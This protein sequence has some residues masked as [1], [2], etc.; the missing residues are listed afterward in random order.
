MDVQI[1]SGDEHRRPSPA[2]WWSSRSRGG[3]RRRA[4]RSAA[5]SRCS[6]TSTSPASTTRSSS[7]STAFPTRT[8]T[9][10]VAEATRLG[11]AVARDGHPRPDR[12]PPLA[13]GDDRRRARA[14][15]RRRDHARAAAERQLLARRPHRGRRALRAARAGALDE[16]A[17]ERGTSVYFPERAVHM[18]PAE[19]STGLCSLNPHVDRL[20]QSCLMEVDRRGDGRPLRAARR[21][22][23]QRRA[24]DVHR[25]ERHP[26]RSRSGRRSTR[27][28]D[29]RAAVRDDAR[30]VRDPEQAPPPPRLDRLRPEGAGDRPRRRGAWSRRSSRAE[31]NVAH[32]LIEEF[33]L[34]ANE[35]VAQ[36]LDEQRRADAVPHPRGAGPAEGRASSRSSSR[37]SATASARRPTQVKPRH[38]QKLVEKMRGTPEEKPIAFLMLRTMQKARYDAAEPRAL[39]PRGGELHALHVADPPLS[40]PRRPPHAARVA[41]RRR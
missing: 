11:T 2:T 22:D 21:R 4:A 9:E 16:E 26:D 27:Y 19:L 25:G 31:R 18:F 28:R 6:A 40:R 7:A 5:S 29:A 30:A 38:F 1:P 36:H 32:R 8:A 12:F 15:L 37:R 33:M 17:Y 39:R 3:R 10:A 13:D 24:D 35:T 34:L 41:P 14:R 23:P 20:V